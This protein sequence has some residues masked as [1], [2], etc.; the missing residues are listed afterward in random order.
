MKRSFLTAAALILATAGFT[1]CPGPEPEPA[2]PTWQPVQSA[3]YKAEVGEWSTFKCS[4]GGFEELESDKSVVLG[5]RGYSDACLFKSTPV[6]VSTY[7]AG[8]KLRVTVVQKGGTSPVK[9]IPF[10]THLFVRFGEVPLSQE[11]LKYMPFAL[12]RDYEAA[13]TITLPEGVKTFD[14]VLGVDPTY[15]SGMSTPADQPAVQL[16]VVKLEVLQ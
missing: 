15:I 8:T 10:Y 6:D 5:L 12:D 2:Q 9:D 7:P 1:A 16:K 14:P 13:Y 11:Q 4:P 3:N